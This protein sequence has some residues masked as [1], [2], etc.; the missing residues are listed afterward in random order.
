MDR[1]TVIGLFLLGLVLT[2]F[3]IY[4]QPSQAE[5]DAENTAATIN[6]TIRFIIFNFNDLKFFFVF[7]KNEWS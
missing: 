5:I 4:N 6:N 1:N 7:C 2:V 3:S